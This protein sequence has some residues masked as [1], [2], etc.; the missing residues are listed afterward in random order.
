MFL[1]NTFP[2]DK[3]GTFTNDFT[4]NKYKINAR[5]VQ[6]KAANY[7]VCPKWHLGA[8]GKT[9]LFVDELLID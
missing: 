2:D 1:D 8:G 7:G 4:F 9:W 3:E 5:Y 6:I